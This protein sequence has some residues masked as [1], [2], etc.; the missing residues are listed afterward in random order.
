MKVFSN[1][2]FSFSS[3]FRCRAAIFFT[4][5]VLQVSASAQGSSMA[6]AGV[7][8]KSRKNTNP[9]SRVHLPPCL[10]HLAF[11]KSGLQ[12]LRNCSKSGRSTSKPTLIPQCVSQRRVT[13]H[14]Q[15][16]NIPNSAAT[17]L[18]SVGDFYVDWASGPPAIIGNDENGKVFLAKKPRDSSETKFLIKM[19]TDANEFY[20]HLAAHKVIHYLVHSYFDE[21][22]KTFFLVAEYSPDDRAELDESGLTAATA[23][24]SSLSRLIGKCSA[25]YTSLGDTD[26]TATTHSEPTT[27]PTSFLKSTGFY[28]KYTV[29]LPT[30]SDGIVT[31]SKRSREWRQMFKMVFPNPVHRPKGVSAYMKAIQPSVQNWLRKNLPSTQNIRKRL[32]ALAINSLE[33]AGR[34]KLAD[35][36]GEEMDVPL[37]GPQECPVCMTN[38]KK[39][40]LPCGHALCKDCLAE[41][42]RRKQKCPECRNPH[43]RKSTPIDRLKVSY[44]KTCQDRLKTD[45]L[46]EIRQ[47]ILTDASQLV[48]FLSDDAGAN[49]LSIGVVEGESASSPQLD[50]SKVNKIKTKIERGAP[51]NEALWAA[52]L[53][54]AGIQADLDQHKMY[55]MRF[56]VKLGAAS[57]LAPPA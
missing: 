45:C 29:R 44:V 5:A 1:L 18:W 31:I 23:F 50:W 49:W 15:F 19:T 40:V 8:P 37:L 30:K 2:L 41:L 53:S 48:T 35:S 46:N 21:A 33:S 10:K 6:S 32:L 13:S 36:S 12:M 47:S 55:I 4:I 28:V 39:V 26:I 42:R 17:D 27:G 22:R 43:I 11:W 51:T 16:Q 3:G 56:L 52:S 24:Y 54:D 57:D 34:Q 7:W 25:A 20:F 38:A 14:V 9:A